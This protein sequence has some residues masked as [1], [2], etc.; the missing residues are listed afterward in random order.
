MRSVF[1]VFIYTCIVV[2]IMHI[3]IKIL[4]Q[5]NIIITKGILKSDP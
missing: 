5:I 4:L 3:A 2:C 1:F